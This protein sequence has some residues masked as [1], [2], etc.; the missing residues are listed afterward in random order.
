MILFKRVI[1]KRE[2][3]CKSKNNLPLADRKTQESLTL[4]E[5]REECNNAKIIKLINRASVFGV[6]RISF[7]RTPHE[8]STRVLCEFFIYFTRHKLIL[9]GASLG[10]FHASQ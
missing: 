9:H 7:D 1:C 3:S 8:P 4:F 5:K 2:N 6:G 10:F